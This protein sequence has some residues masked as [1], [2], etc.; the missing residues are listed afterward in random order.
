MLALLFIATDHD[1][2]AKT[3]SNHTNEHICATNRRYQVI[4][5]SKSD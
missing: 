2:L 4:T 3:A 1:F 5:K